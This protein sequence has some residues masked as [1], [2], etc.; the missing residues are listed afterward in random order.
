L[1]E[2]AGDYLRRDGFVAEDEFFYA[3]LPESYEDVL[4]RVSQSLGWP[5]FVLPLSHYFTARLRSQFDAVIH[6]DQTR[7]LEP[8]ERTAERDVGETPTGETP[9]GE[10]PTGEVP[11]T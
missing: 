2:C 10:V 6:I 5:G 11:E 9:T 8:W 4:Y 7:A 3:A 1:R